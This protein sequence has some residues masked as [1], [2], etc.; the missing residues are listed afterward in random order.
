VKALSAR[1][2]RLEEVMADRPE[3]QQQLANL[4]YRLVDLRNIPFGLQGLML[5]QPPT[6]RPTTPAS[7][8]WTDLLDF[9]NRYDLATVVQRLVDGELWRDRS[10]ESLAIGS[11]DLVNNA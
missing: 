6:F 9:C 7:M 11:D 8:E 1:K 3:D 4:C 5:A 10:Q 2:W